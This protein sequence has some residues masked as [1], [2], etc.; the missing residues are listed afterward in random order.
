MMKV[1]PLTTC[2]REEK[3]LMEEFVLIRWVHFQMLQIEK[4]LGRFGTLLSPATWI[5]LNVFSAHS[6]PL[7]KRSS[8]ENRLTIDSL[9]R[10]KILLT[11]FLDSK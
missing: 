10:L 1:G 8:P 3:L 4:G 5:F 2:Q 11:A 6:L 7:R 9:Q